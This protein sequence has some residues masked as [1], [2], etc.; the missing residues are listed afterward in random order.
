[1]A[2]KSDYYEI[3]GVGKTA[4]ADEIKSAY[5]KLAIRFHPD[6]NPGDKAAEEKFKEATEAYEVLS[7]QEK[8]QTYDQFGHEGI[9]RMGGGFSGSDG[10]EFQGFEDI[11]GGNFND[12]FGGI[13]GDSFSGGRRGGRRRSRGSD[14]RYDFAI[15]ME[16]LFKDTEVKVKLRKKE[17][18]SVC[19][20][21]GAKPG[22]KASTCSTCDGAGVVRQ[23]QGFFSLQTTCPRCRGTGKTISSPCSSCGGSG[24][25]ERQKTITVK[26]P[27]GIED[28]SRIRIPGEGEAGENGSASGDLFVVVNVNPNKFYERHGSDLYCKIPISMTLAAL[29][30][31]I[32]IT[33]LDGR[34][35]SVKVPAGT[36]EGRILRLN[37]MGLPHFRSSGRGDLNAIVTIQIPQ[38][39]S[40]KAKNLLEEFSKLQKEPSNIAPLPLH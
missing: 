15:D 23:T 30:G 3:L 10:S 38:N 11:F 2:G 8:R 18:C 28:G 39:L 20:G 14:L 29:G 27:A 32:E 40:G 36:Q 25:E 34:T 6:K 37:N 9:N 22:T 26:I 12:F 21:T 1:M 13:F 7:N 31:Q 19:G 16:Q 5:R 24:F 4:S 35:V 17:S 33:S